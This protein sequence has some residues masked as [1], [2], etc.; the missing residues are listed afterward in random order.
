MDNVGRP[1]LSCL[2]GLVSGMHRIDTPLTVA[3]TWPEA[4]AG[5]G[6]YSSAS[7]RW[8]VSGPEPLEEAY[9]WRDRRAINVLLEAVNH[10]H[11]RAPVQVIEK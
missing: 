5:P 2:Y 10:G 3:C 9:F 4:I 11:L 7:A 1:F 8:A 6:A